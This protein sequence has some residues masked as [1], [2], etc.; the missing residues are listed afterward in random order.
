MFQYLEE[1]VKET[2]KTLQAT[3]R[4][5]VNAGDFSTLPPSLNVLVH[6]LSE[7]KEIFFE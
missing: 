4:S 7:L 2:V 6:L 1:L 5:K 3:F